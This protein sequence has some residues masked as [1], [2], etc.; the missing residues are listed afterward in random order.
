[1]ARQPLAEMTTPYQA[2]DLAGIR[3]VQ[4]N[5]VMFL[6]HPHYPIQKLSR[7]SDTG[8]TIEEYKLTNVP[9]RK[10]N[11]TSSRIKATFVPAS[12][13]DW[14]DATDYE[15]GD[16]VK[17]DGTDAGDLFYLTCVK[18]HTSDSTVAALIPVHTDFGAAA[19]GAAVGQTD[20]YWYCY[21]AYDHSVTT[22][23]YDDYIERGAPVALSVESGLVFTAGMV[24]STFQVSHTPIQTVLEYNDDDADAA[25]AAY[26]SDPFRVYGDWTLLTGG[27][28]Y[29]EVKLERTFDYGT[30]W[31]TIRVM[32]SVA[33]AAQNF[34][35]VG[36]ENLEDVFYRVYY[37][38]DVDNSKITITFNID[39]NSSDG[40]VFITSLDGGVTIPDGSGLNSYSNI[41]AHYKC[42]DNAATSVVTDSGGS[43]RNAVLYANTTAANTTTVYDAAV[44][45]VTVDGTP[46]SFH[47]DPATKDHFRMP[48]S[49]AA[50]F[51]TGS[52]SF[53]LWFRLDALPSSGDTFCIIGENNSNGTQEKMVV[54]VDSDGLL[55]LT[56]GSV[57]GSGSTV[58]AIDTWYM[59]ACT[60]NATTKKMSLYLDGNLEC[61]I[62][63]NSTYAPYNNDL[64]QIGMEFDS[65]T[66]SESMDGY[67]DNVLAYK[68]ELTAEEVVKLLGTTISAY[69]IVRTPIYDSYSSPDGASDYTGLFS[70][71]AWSPLRGYPKCGCFFEERFCVAGTF[72]DMQTI[73]CSRT[74]DF[75]NFKAGVNDDDALAYTIGADQ[76]NEIMWLAPLTKL[77]IG[78]QCGEFILGAT[79]PDEPLTPTNVKCVRQSTYGSKDIESVVINDAVLFL[80]T[81]AKKIREYVYNFEKDGYVAPDMT[82]LANHITGNSILEMAAQQNPDTVLWTVRDDG[83]LAS[84]TYERN[85][86]V[87]AWA[88]YLFGGIVESTTVT[89]GDTEDKVWMIV[90]RI[91]DGEEVRYLEVM[92]IQASSVDETLF[93]DCAMLFEEAS[94]ATGVIT[95]TDLNHL[96]GQMVAIVADGTV[97]SD[98]TDS[99]YTVTDG[100]VSF[101]ADS[102]VVPDG[103]DLLNYGD[104]VAHYKLNDNLESSVVTDSKG[105]YDAILYDSDTEADTVDVYDADVYK[106]TVDTT[107]ASFHF[108]IAA[109]SYNIRM[110][111]SLM[112]ALGSGDRTYSCWF[113]A[114]SLGTYRIISEDR[115]NGTN[116][117]SLGITADGVLTL[118]NYATTNLGTA[119]VLINTW[120]LLTV[121]YN[122]ITRVINVYLNNVLDISIVAHSSGLPASLDVL[123]FGCGLY[124]TDTE[125]AFFDGYLDNFLVYNKELTA[126]QVAALIYN[127]YAKVYVGLPYTAKL[128]T[129]P[130]NP[131][132]SQVQGRTKRIA[133]VIARFYRSLDCEIGC[134]WDD[135]QSIDFTTSTISNRWDFIELSD[136]AD[137]RITG[138]YKLPYTGGYETEASIYI[139]SSKPVPLN[140]L[141][142]MPDFE[143]YG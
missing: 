33:D 134:S 93:I 73:W 2:K 58:A 102:D 121:T 1:M 142:I 27:T 4:S 129:M 106:V 10:I 84:F 77:G 22:Y 110:P 19:S 133:A 114:D 49:V 15:V 68:V 12:V 76:N 116:I 3:Y 35:I 103:S 63:T 8:W 65:T 71:S 91:I 89:P 138:D 14:A 101:A 24:G 87:T 140:L 130:L 119:P 53:A 23:Y 72:S 100:E 26:T 94:A 13:A 96:E 111:S 113:R 124:S 139:K 57:S 141:C 30:T 28:W 25:D 80:Q 115:L 105:D 79:S 40:E 17:I 60:Y 36:N 132:G 125:S 137:G 46:A 90:N 70:E 59:L 127:N 34:E 5:D 21:C 55:S 75:P 50:A 16:M 48:S 11:T 7:T 47:F 37:D 54:R 95:L 74:D 136:L 66:V 31:E 97:I 128:R 69:G 56:S 120:Y 61:N 43:S 67:V 85:Q 123:Y 88:R 122:S 92:T 118:G 99:D 117:I 44:Y 45:K 81:N 9:Y 62:T 131:S 108:D 104:A 83:Q 126:A 20:G 112:L 86:D 109:N 39:N 18:S 6:F 38:C 78:T 64:I 41:V 29:G 32:H 52:R 107:P 82:V 51:G 42:N 135:T 98:G 143:V